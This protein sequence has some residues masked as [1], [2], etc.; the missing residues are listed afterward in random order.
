MAENEGNPQEARLRGVSPLRDIAFGLYFGFIGVAVYFVFL[1][2]YGDPDR[3]NIAALAVPFAIGEALGL[4]Y[5]FAIKLI[6]NKLHLPGISLYRIAALHLPFLILMLYPFRLQTM[7]G[8]LN[9]YIPLSLVAIYGVIFLPRTL[10]RMMRLAAWLRRIASCDRPLEEGEIEREGFARVAL[11]LVRSVTPLYAMALTGSAFPLFC[12]SKLAVTK[13]L[14]ALNFNRVYAGYFPWVIEQ[15]D[16]G[17]A[18]EMLTYVM[19]IAGLALEILIVGLLPIDRDWAQRRIKTVFGFKSLLL[20]VA[21]YLSLLLLDLL[22][23]SFVGPEGN[24]PLAVSALLA[25]APLGGLFLFGVTKR[26]SS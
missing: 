18:T 19:T 1:F 16:L 26:A 2:R 5:F 23:Y 11:L 22:L 6:I 12:F 9:Q 17:K 10:R 3:G 4:A 24:L 21:F 20:L 8:P 13:I 14:D 25:G 15:S 7:I